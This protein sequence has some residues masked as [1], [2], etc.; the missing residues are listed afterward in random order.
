MNTIRS[1]LALCL[2]ALFIVSCATTQS[3]YSILGNSYHPKP[4]EYDVQVFRDSAPQRPFV[5]ISRL[6]VH[7]EKTHFIGSSLDDALPELKKQARLSGAD[8]IIDIRESFSMVG[9]TRIYHVTVTGVRY[10]DSQ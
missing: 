7:L 9:E 5:R 10:T 6:D 8:A 1:T 2:V 4:E 3:R